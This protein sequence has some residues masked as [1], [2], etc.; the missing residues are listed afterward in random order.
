MNA[1]YPL[2]DLRLTCSREAW[3]FAQA[4]RPAID[5]HWRRIVAQKPTLWNGEVLLCTEAEVADGCLAARFVRTDYAS[6]IAWRDWQRRDVK[7]WSCFGVPAVFS[8]DGALLI[9]VMGQWTLNAGKAYP[10]SGSLE[11]RDIKGDDSVD[12]LGSM[13]TEL[14]EETGLDLSSAVA[15]EIVAIFDGPR[16]AVARHHA[17]PHSFAEMQAIF[18]DH[19]RQEERPELDGIEAVWSR[20]QIDSRMPG[21]AQEIIR[22]FHR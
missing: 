22:Y 1:V 16:I 15:G 2:S 18:A 14:H 21:Y 10:P 20:S 13:R 5:A 9:G 19:S 6:F 7:V 17:F 11:P 12:L 3:D 4:E 8:S